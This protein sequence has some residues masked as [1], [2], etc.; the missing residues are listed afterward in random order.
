MDD[1]DANE[2]DL[3]IIDDESLE[4]LLNDAFDK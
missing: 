4:Q 2:I 3:I 1:I